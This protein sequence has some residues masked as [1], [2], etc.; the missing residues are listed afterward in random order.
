MT[1]KRKVIPLIERQEHL[2]RNMQEA[3]AFMEQE[4]DGFDPD[5]M[6]ILYTKKDQMAYVPASKNR[7]YDQGDIY[8]DVNMWLR[9]WVDEIQDN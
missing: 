4:L 3:L 8:W 9:A 6:I 1:D 2:Q 5:R 7:D